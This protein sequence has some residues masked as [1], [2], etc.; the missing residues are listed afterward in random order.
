LFE[1]NCARCH[2]LNWSI[3]D[4][5]NQ[6]LP[7]ENLLGPP[8]GGGSVGF[9]LRGGEE[10]RRFSNTRDADN[11][12]LPN[13]GLLSQIA[14]VV[15]GSDANVAYGNKGQGSGK[16]P[17]QCNTALKTNPNISLPHYGCEL[18]YSSDVT[19]LAGTPVLTDKPN[20]PIDDIMIE[21]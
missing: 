2:T 18:T 19:N 14:F 1:I 12:L 5:T 16:M 20:T 8:G 15:N 13:S 11:N 3:F 9:S 10:A 17:G 21:E 4:P 7:P 6:D